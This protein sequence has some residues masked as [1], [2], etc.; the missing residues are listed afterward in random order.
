MHS[1]RVLTTN[2]CSLLNKL[3]ELSCRLAE[4]DI[5]LITETW[6]RDSDTIQKYTDG[7]VEYRCDRVGVVG[8]GCLL[9][10]RGHFPQAPIPIP[11]LSD[12]IQLVGC[13]LHVN[14]PIQ[15]LGVYRSPRSSAT[16]DINFLNFVKETSRSSYRLCIM[17]DFN[18]PK[19]DW[20]SRS[21]RAAGFEHELISALDNHALVQ[22]V[23]N[24][25]RFRQHQ[26]PSILDLVISRR[27]DD[28]ADLT[29]SDPLGKSDH[30]TLTF[31]FVLFDPL[32]TAGFYRP[33]HKIDRLK[34]AE[35]ASDMNWSSVNPDNSWP[36]LTEN[37]RILTAQFAPLTKVGG[38]NK[39]PWL[40]ASVKKALKIKRK[41]WS[42]YV[43]LKESW[44]Y[45]RYKRFRN[46]AIAIARRA[47]C[48]YESLIAKTAKV[49]PKRF[50]SYAK[51]KSKQKDTVSAVLYKDGEKF[52]GDQR[53]AEIFCDYFCSVF[54]VPTR[55]RLPLP[56]SNALTFEE[57]TAT[58]VQTALKSLNPWKSTGPDGIHPAVLIPL[59]PLLTDT[60]VQVFNNSL[61]TC[62]LPADWK[63]ATVVPIYKSGDRTV[64]RNY[65]P[66]SL[67]SIVVKLLERIIRDRI[68]GFLQ[69]QGYFNPGQHGFLK[70]RS[71]LTNLLAFFDQVTQLLD[72]GKE[73]DVCYLD[74]Q[75]AFDSVNH[76]LLIWKLR[77]L[78]IN[79]TLCDWIEEFLKN[80]TFRV[81]V[82]NTLSKVATPTS[83]VPQGSIL[84]PLMFLIY[85]ND[86]TE[87]LN[88]PCFLYA[89]DIKLVGDSNT[90][91]LQSDLIKLVDWT[92]KW[93][94]PLNAL[95]CHLLTS[96]SQRTLTLPLSSGP[97]QL[98]S[99]DSARDLGIM[100]T[101]KFT[102][103]SQCEAAAAKALRALFSL[104]SVII[105]RTSEVM[106]PLYSAIV[107]PHLEYCVQAWAPYLKKDVIVLERVQRLATRMMLDVRE[108][109]YKD[110][111]KRLKL[112]SLERRRLRGDLIEVFKYSLDPNS[113]PVG[114]LFT[115][116][117]NTGLRGHSLTLAKVRSRLLVRHH[118]F[119]N[120]VVNSW[121]KLPATVVL[122][123]SV[124]SFKSALDA[125]WDDIFP[126]LT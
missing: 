6:L 75:K 94:L 108:L 59:G 28:V 52:E 81:R 64:P 93:D 9:L 80:R 110:R 41:A 62:C 67:T 90:S 36:L 66:V 105:N 104:R 77:S 20:L 113:S 121:N 26:S 14:P 125:V 122:S 47:R 124:D 91:V 29:V 43:D 17:G 103:S 88:S 99:V 73:V 10:V 116:R 76:E 15:F 7:F 38:R 21:P 44:A 37:F 101:S 112:F 123:T 70:G 18:A 65:R 19:I 89:D 68:C 27:H 63:S 100:V 85:I 60:L 31:R 48:K 16:S 45:D 23:R 55:R 5:A 11:N 69:A 82:R 102:P 117:R 24:V 71:C 84:G 114:H 115:L 98:N 35:A 40:T 97:H 106:L 78:G 51:L 13:V 3:D 30:Y 34:L 46:K 22:H 56:A 32:P 74:F 54:R 33:F 87:G 107:R 92:Q 58:E 72:E 61:A 118:F 39:K 57:V 109:S 4:V 49:N 111:L 1:L 79:Q 12:D 95:K 126:D 96:A 53:I 42:L 86:I 2:A 119:A 50:F 83:G 120:R 8:G 25:T